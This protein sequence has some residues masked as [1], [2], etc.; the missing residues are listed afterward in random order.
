MKQGGLSYSI[1]TLL[2]V[3]LPIGAV[4]ALGATVNRGLYSPFIEKDVPE[5][6]DVSVVR[7]LDG[8]ADPGQ[9]ESFIPKILRV[10]VG[11]NSTVFWI[12]DDRAL[13]TV[14]DGSLAGESP[15]PV[16][17]ARANMENIL[18]PERSFTFSFTQPGVY[19]YYCFPHP[20]MRARVLVEPGGT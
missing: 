18:A 19:E 11:V 6:G 12:N 14:T 9:S 8:S 3:L 1:L 20:W 2:L 13:H 4:A 15:D 7:I 17:F 16:F 5:S 10:L